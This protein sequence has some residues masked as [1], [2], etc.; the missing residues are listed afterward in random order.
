MTETLQITPRLPADTSPFSKGKDGYF[1]IELKRGLNTKAG[2]GAIVALLKLNDANPNLSQEQVDGYAVTLNEIT[3]AENS[4]ISIPNNGLTFLMTSVST[5]ATENQLVVTL[6]PAD[7]SNIYTLHLDVLAAAQLFLPRDNELFVEH[8]PGK[9]YY[10][11]V[12]FAPTSDA[13]EQ[14]Q[15]TATEE[16]PWSTPSEAVIDILAE[17]GPSDAVLTMLDQI[18]S[19]NADPIS[20]FAP[21]L[22]EDSP[23]VI[24][25]PFVEEPFQNEPEYI[26][27]QSEEAGRFG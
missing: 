19:V 26:S 5:I 3:T 25:V 15:P 21:V 11:T 4:T 20:D 16:Q 23:S 27:A 9:P 18:D 7:A 2:P 17:D 12:D 14:D 1:S 13:V 22:S 24:E 6:A 10:L 8:R